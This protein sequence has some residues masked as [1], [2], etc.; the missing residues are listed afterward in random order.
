MEVRQQHRICRSGG[1]AVGKYA[2]MY[3][4]YLEFNFIGLI[5]L[6]TIRKHNSTW[7]YASGLD[8]YVCNSFATSGI[9]DACPL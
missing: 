5:C 9:Y 6:I 8:R 1:C 3:E 7:R 2:F 4:F